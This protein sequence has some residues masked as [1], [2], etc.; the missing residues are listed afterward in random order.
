MIRHATLA[1]VPRIVE[2]AERFFALSEYRELMTGS[3]VH[4][5]A[6]AERLLAQNDATI[7]VAD[8]QGVVGMLAIYVFEHPYSGERVASEL[9]W[10]VEPEQRGAGVRL[11][12]AAEQWAAA[13]GAKVL[14]MIAPNARVGE[15]YAKAGYVPV[16]TTFQ[17]RVA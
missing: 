2:M 15:F 5:A 16:E 14:Q 10:W 9:V 4:L 1:D 8:A 3:P 13:Q 11:L 6:F 17:R 7:L 12:R